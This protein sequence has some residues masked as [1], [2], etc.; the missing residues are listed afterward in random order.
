MKWIWETTAVFQTKFKQFAYAM[1]QALNDEGL[2]W[3]RNNRRIS[4]MQL[5]YAGSF[6]GLWEGG[7][8][9]VGEAHEIDHETRQ[10]ILNARDDLCFLAKG[11]RAYLKHTIRWI[12]K[13][14][15]G[16]C[17]ATEKPLKQLPRE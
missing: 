15:Q 5:N 12:G 17:H 13:T 2:S 14:R 8:A 7:N 1:R 6:S 10:R 3:I 16:F 9:L 11:K 4:V